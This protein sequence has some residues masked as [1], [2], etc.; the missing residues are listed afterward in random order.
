[1]EEKER[2]RFRT[3]LTEL[4][5][6]LTTDFE[7][8]RDAS[9]EEWGADLPDINDEATRTMNRRLL[10][11]IGARSFDVI[12]KIDIALDR[13]S[14][15]DYGVCQECGE[16]IPVSRLELLPYAELCVECQERIEREKQ[17]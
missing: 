7:K 6:R 17:S 9:S 10:L 1:M 3:I 5:R 12:Q 4:R 16:D 8:I 11:S 14:E 15:G 2:E 13:I